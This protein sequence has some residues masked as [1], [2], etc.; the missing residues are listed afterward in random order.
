MNTQI[1][2]TL[3][4]VGKFLL[5]GSFLVI[6]LYLIFI[7]RR[8][9]LAIKNL[10]VV[11]EE[12]RENIDEILNTVPG[13]TKNFEKISGDLAEDVSA[14]NGTVSNIAGIAEKVTSIKNIKSNFVKEKEPTKS[15]NIVLEDE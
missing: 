14:F 5:W 8:I 3:S 9:Y 10:T 2:F 12:N 7:L 4:D 15:S 11:V 13:I 6:L 1:V